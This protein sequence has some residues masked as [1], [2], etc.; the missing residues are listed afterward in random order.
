MKCVHCGA[1]L[2]DRE[3]ICTLCGKLAKVPEAAPI[4]TAREPEPAE[5]AEE[6]TPAAPPAA[7]ETTSAF[8]PACKQY[9]YLDAN[10]CCGEG[11]QVKT[12]GDTSTEQMRPLSSI[13][14]G[15]YP[16]D[17]PIDKFMDNTS[18]QGIAASLPPQISG[19]NWG[20]FLLT[21][22]WGIGNSVWIAL[23][24]FIPI[25]SYVMPW[26][27]LFKGN[28]WAWR[29]KRW[30]S[31]EQFLD[32]QRKWMIAGIVYLVIIVLLVCA[33]TVSIV[34]PVIMQGNQ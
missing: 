26:I 21:W 28:E 14:P 1:E 27:L 23:L 7:S 11:H 19:L 20:G 4:A 6:T 30:D 31:V 8:C 29:N 18:G 15:T 17:I 9:V 25:V 33:I 34:L 5:K 12:P 3:E 2:S 22:I 13:P 32:I 24:S 10:G 16:G